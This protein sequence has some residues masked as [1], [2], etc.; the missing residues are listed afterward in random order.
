MLSAKPSQMSSERFLHPHGT[1]RSNEKVSSATSSREK[2]LGSSSFVDIPLQTFSATS[3]STKLVFT[4]W[5]GQPSKSRKRP[6][7]QIDE[8]VLALSVTI[9]LALLVLIGVPLSAILPQKYVVQLPINI[10][11]PFYVY[12]DPGAFDRLYSAFMKHP[13]LNFTVILSINHGPTTNA[14]P[15]GVY[16][17]PIKR[18]STLPNVQTI[19]YIDTAYGARDVEIVRKEI[20][21]YAGW[22]NSNIAISGI[23]FDHTPT[24]DVDDARAY[25]KNVSATVRHSDGFLDPRMVI[26]NAGRL[27]DVN[28]ASYRADVTVVFE[29]EYKDVPKRGELRGKLRDL[30]GRRED[31][32]ELVHSVPQNVSRGGIRNIINAARRN[33]GW[34]FV[35]NRT[36]DDSIVSNPTLDFIV[37]INPHNGPGSEPWWP[38]IDYVR[39]IPRF[40]AQPNVRIVGYVHTIYCKRPVEQL[41]ADIDRYASWS[42]DDSLPGLSLGGIFFDETPDV[43]SE[44]SKEYLDVITQKVKETDGLVGERLVMV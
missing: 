9:T 31:Y 29:G 36:G 20:A 42:R 5:H 2:L 41:F 17:T 35:T 40:N 25:L 30:H 12:P 10:L 33:V 39:E 3:S 15:S 44:E 32:A 37:I 16:I 28:M 26:H 14:W 8:R 21:T 6:P 34:L 24:E 27:P 22:N 19:G 43:F 13:D 4:D 7:H 23:F 18:L 1:T 11:V 38:N